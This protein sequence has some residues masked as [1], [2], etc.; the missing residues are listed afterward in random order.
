[1]QQKQLVADASLSFEGVFFEKGLTLESDIEPQIAVLGDGQALQQVVDILLDN[2][3]KYSAPG[4]STSVCL[5]SV[6]RNR[7]RLSVSNPGAPISQEDLTNIF[8]RFYRT[9]KARSRDGSFG[10]GL[11]IAETI[12]RQHHGKIWATSSGG[13]NAFHVE[14]NKCK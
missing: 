14:L 12:V 5:C 4:G 11:P 8:C 3:Q 2:A 1:M 10:L 9:D 6:G 13:I 7:C